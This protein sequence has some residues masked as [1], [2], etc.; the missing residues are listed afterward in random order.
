MPAT[1]H[2]KSSKKAHKSAVKI[3]ISSTKKWYQHYLFFA[4]LIPVILFGFW[5][6]QHVTSGADLVL[7]VLPV[8]PKDALYKQAS[9]PIDRRVDDLIQRM[10]LEEKIGQ[11]AMVNKNSIVKPADLSTYSLGA[12]L[13][14][15]GAKPKDN[16]P[17]GWQ[18]M[19]QAIKSQG[20]ASRLQIPLLYG[21]DAT[22]GHANV[23]GATVFPHNIGLGAAHDPELVKAIAADTANELAATGINW[24]FSPSLDAPQDIRW[25]R[26]YEAFSSDPELNAALGSAYIN[27][28]QKPVSPGGTQILATAKHYI[29]AGSML[30]GTSYN[31]NFKIDQATTPKNNQL[32][33][34]EYIVPFK[35]AV[36]EGVGSVMVG[37]NHYGN[38]RVVD[39]KFLITDTLKTDL[40]FKGFV[41]TDWYGMYEFSGT[42]PYHANVSAINAGVDMAML[43]YEYKSF[44]KDVRLAVQKS[45]IPQS[46]IDDA[47]HRILYQKFKANLFD[48]MQP[49]EQITQIGT[50]EHRALA[51]QAVAKSAV[52]L[53]N[54]DGL[55][56]L[57][58]NSG[59]ILIAGSGADNIGRQCGA[60]TVEWQGIDGNW[61]PGAT[62]ILQG[63]LAAV[64]ANSKVE[65]NKDAKF[66]LATTK[67][68]VGIVVV[69][70][71][72]YAE[73]WGDKA[74][75]T[76]DAADNLAIEKMHTLANKVILVTVTGR[77]LIMT[78]QIN[79]ADTVVAAWL[80]GSEG[81]GIADVL[82]GDQPFTA[83]L[84][85]AWPAK[86]SQ[87][88][89]SSAGK[90]NDQTA[91]L[92]SKGFSF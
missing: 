30:W 85:I 60:W 61:L 22:H 13:S 72:P 58:K 53:K 19:V 74:A 69:S 66:A 92:F 2:K 41:V 46:R 59:H 33:Q 76:L 78:N 4:A 39:S 48:E 8:P 84:P 83:T 79:Q 82:F 37:L 15:A 56:P 68:D 86:M 28:M 35:A 64:G 80:P 63:I 5:Y 12:V 45:E 70:E 21:I 65:Y 75:L 7:P 29:G 18:H 14:G 20:A 55:L 16:T 27:G 3:P 44:I 43:P 67:A 32:L 38:E 36:N 24:D 71:K 6:T 57:R 26:T 31:K 40:G 90:T 9:Q 50:S 11:M 23:P 91:P 89:I 10:S 34:S 51:R 77:P 25:G 54:Q 62:S 81:A 1:T 42:S 49:A 73:G 17:A 87:V 52:L 88:P 47:V